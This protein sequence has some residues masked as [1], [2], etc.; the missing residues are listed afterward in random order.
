MKQFLVSS[1]Q[2][3]VAD[4]THGQSRIVGSYHCGLVGEDHFP[5]GDLPPGHHEPPHPVALPNV[6]QYVSMV[7]GRGLVVLVVVELGPGVSVPAG[8]LGGGGSVG[9]L[10]TH[11]SLS[12]PPLTRPNCPLTRPSWTAGWCQRNILTFSHLLR[13]EIPQLILQLCSPLTV[14]LAETTKTHF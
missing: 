7:S 5:G 3:L 6:V 1:G 2:L 13:Y 14:P 8:E 11:L 9:T 12:S 10:D 4:Q